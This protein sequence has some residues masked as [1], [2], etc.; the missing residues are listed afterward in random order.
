MLADQ[1]IEAHQKS[2]ESLQLRRVV[3]LHQVTEDR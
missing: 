2:F 1:S 3:A